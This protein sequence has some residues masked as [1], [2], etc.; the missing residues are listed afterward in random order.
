[1]ASVCHWHVVVIML[2]II[3]IIV[4]IIITIQVPLARIMLTT[5]D[6]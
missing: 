6:L 5:K 1:M 3:I 2:V 4:V